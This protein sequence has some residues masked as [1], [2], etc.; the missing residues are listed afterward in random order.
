M[1]SFDQKLLLFDFDGV[2]VDSLE[3]YED[4]V[5][6][7]LERLGR[8]IIRNRED[9]LALYHDNF[10]R[11]VEKR[12]IDLEAFI[13]VLAEIRPHID[14]SLIQPYDMMASVLLELAKRHRL[15]LISS[16]TEKT[17]SVLLNR[18]NVQECFE[19]VVGSDAL[20]NK[21]EKILRAQS[22]SG[23]SRDSVY[24]I[25][26]TAGDI[27][28]AR[29]AGIKTIAVTWGWHSREILESVSP[30]FLIDTAPAL[31]ELFTREPSFHGC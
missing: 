21:T 17:I 30:D 29:R 27:R 8:P 10:Y 7:C 9:F 25:G 22:E 24:Y 2:L 16:N 13:A 3:V 18:M 26:D 12:G 5:R 28:E 31:L 20:L 15:M 6:Q 4:V 14:I 19:A 23:M 11:E 1:K